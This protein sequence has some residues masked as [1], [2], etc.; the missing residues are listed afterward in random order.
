MTWQKKVTIACHKCLLGYIPVWQQC[1]VIVVLALAVW[2]VAAAEIR[3]A[4]IDRRIEAHTIA[5]TRM[6]YA[7]GILEKMDRKLDDHLAKGP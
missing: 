5:L 1:V 7:I 4:E 2:R 6:E 3:A